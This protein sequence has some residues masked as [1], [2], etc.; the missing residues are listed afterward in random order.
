MLGWRDDKEMAKN[1]MH[2]REGGRGS[3]ER[4]RRK[5][6][7]NMEEGKIVSGKIKRD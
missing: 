7:R 4:K 1:C 3:S 5:I 6:I 2:G